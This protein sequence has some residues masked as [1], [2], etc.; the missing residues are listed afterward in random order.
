MTNAPYVMVHP[1]FKDKLKLEAALRGESVVKYT[2][3]LVE[4]KDAIK[5]LAEQW[6]EKY[7]GKTKKQGHLDLP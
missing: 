3:K 1:K 2:Q 4:S 7:N 5:E 6:K